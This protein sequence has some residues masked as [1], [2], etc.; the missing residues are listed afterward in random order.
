MHSHANVCNIPRRKEIL[1]DAACV[2]GGF[3]LDALDASGAK[4]QAPKAPKSRPA[5]R[6]KAYS[7]YCTSAHSR[8]SSTVTSLPVV[9]VDRRR[10]HNQESDSG[11]GA[12][13]P[14]RRD[15]GGSPSGKSTPKAYMLHNRKYRRMCTICKSLC[16][17]WSYLS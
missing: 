3:K 12:V 6:P 13:A 5:D 16:L 11:S 8:V 1:S 4:G 15:T 17:Y 2:Q 10:A 14:L 7:A 9:N